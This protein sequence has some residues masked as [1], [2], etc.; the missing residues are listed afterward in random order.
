MSLNKSEGE[1]V[2]AF[3]SDGILKHYS[4]DDIIVQGD[5]EPDGVYFIQ[6]GYVKS[7]FYIPAGPAEPT[8]STRS[9]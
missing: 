3:F 8:T 2:A 9:R 6:S 1:S 7:L 4:K 5:E